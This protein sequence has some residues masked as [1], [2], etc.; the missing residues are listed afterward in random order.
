MIPDWLPDW[1]D[2]GAY[3]YG[4]V[5]A[6]LD[7]KPPDP[8]I[9]NYRGWAWE[10]LRRSPDYQRDWATLALPHYDD[11]RSFGDG[12]PIKHFQQQYGILLPIDPARGAEVDPSFVMNMLADGRFLP[13]DRDERTANPAREVLVFRKDWP[14]ASQLERARRYLESTQSTSDRK[15]ATARNHVEKWPFYL[16]ILDAEAAGAA[17]REIASALFP[18]TKDEYPDHSARQQVKNDR[19]AAHRLRDGEYRYIVFGEMRRAEGGPVK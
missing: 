18:E 15:V 12:V 19:R 13:N 16:R 11:D 6:R 17:D 7:S 14:L 9:R 10:Y 2:A 8:R 1:K 3:P 4:K 5:V